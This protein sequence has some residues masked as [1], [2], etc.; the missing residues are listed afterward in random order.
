MRMPPSRFGVL[1]TLVTIVAGAPLVRAQTPAATPAAA[2][3]GE[4][5]LFG[6]EDV[7]IEAATKSSISLSKAPGAVSVITARQIRE[8]GARTI[9]DALRLVA[10]VNVRW[11]PM[12]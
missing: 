11:N 6:E 7:K 5:Q 9:P 12:V 8:S 2:V 3:I 1:A 10:G 4:V